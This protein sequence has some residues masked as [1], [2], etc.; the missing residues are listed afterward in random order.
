MTHSLAHATCLD[1]DGLNRLVPSTRRRRLGAAHHALAGDDAAEHD[2][3]A[4]QMR[5]GDGGDEE[6]AA[7]CPR[8]GIGHGEKEGRVVLAAGCVSDVR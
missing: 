2:V 7:I 4:V 6:L 8:P 1:D 5:R 3:L